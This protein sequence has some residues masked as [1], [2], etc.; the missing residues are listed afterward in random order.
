[1]MFY[2]VVSFPLILRTIKPCELRNVFHKLM[3]P[4]ELHQT[5]LPCGPS[6]RCLSNITEVVFAFYSNKPY[7]WDCSQIYCDVLLQL[8]NNFL[9]Y[10]IQHTT[11]LLSCGL[12]S[13]LSRSTYSITEPASRSNCET[14]FWCNPSDHIATLSYTS[15]QV[16]LL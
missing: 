4:C 14:T 7:E 9:G 6:I 15:S 13:R 16:G 12:L 10:P 1:M 5:R 3:L 11:Y 2:S 8:M